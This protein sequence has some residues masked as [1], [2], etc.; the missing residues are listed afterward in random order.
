MTLNEFQG[1]CKNA[2][3]VVPKIEGEHL[4]FDQEVNINLA[5]YYKNKEDSNNFNPTYIDSIPENIIFRNKG[6]VYLNYIK[7]IPASTIF[8]NTGDVYML[9]SVVIP[10]GFKGFRN[11]GN[12]SPENFKIKKP[13]ILYN[14]SRFFVDFLNESNNEVSRMILA[15]NNKVVDPDLLNA[16]YI[17]CA[18]DKSEM[19]SYL[20]T[21]KIYRQY[22]AY[23]KD[24]TKDVAIK[25][26]FR[27]YIQRNYQSYFDSTDRS[28]IKIGRFLKKILP[29]ITD[30]QVEQ[31]VNVYRA[32]KT[33]DDY[34][35]SIVRGDEIAKYYDRANQ[36]CAP[37]SGLHGSCMNYTDKN[38]TKA[39]YMEFYA[40]TPET[41]GLL[42]LKHKG[43]EKIRGRAFIWTSTDG[44]TYVDYIYISKYS[45][46]N[47]YR[48]YIQDNKFLS[49]INNS[50]IKDFIINANPECQ[51]VKT[52]I[53][54]LDSFK[55]ERD[56][57]LITSK[58]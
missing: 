30:T 43:S 1:V 22:S 26:T 34:E 14:F 40:K 24:E 8:E 18:M 25:A 16:S 4:I 35:L 33:I 44:R 36:D 31:F 6:Y 9:P 52:M 54:Y 53:P 56:K 51:K 28:R 47:I 5:H 29:N 3:G 41:C 2:L 12:I 11:R 46:M 10:K 55:Y 15:L 19:I 57:N 42:I 45:E 27:N 13:A 49:N 48:K 32:F 58:Y 7:E 20:P 50:P 17:D 37:G 21:D 38:D 39:K 23:L